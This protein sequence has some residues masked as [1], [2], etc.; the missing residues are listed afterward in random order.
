MASESLQRKYR[1][2]YAKLL[3][4]Y[5]KPYRE[6]FGETMGQT[7]ND[8]CRER[9]KA[10]KGLLSFVL[11]TFFETSAAIVRENATMIVRCCM[12]RGSTIFLRVVISLIAMAAL[13][14]CIFPLPRMVGQEAAKTPDTAW[15]VYLFL[16]GAY[17][18]AILFFVALYQAFKLLTYVD[19]NKAF[20]ELSAGALGSI[21]YCA[22]TI[23]ILMVGGIAA[24]MALSFG[25]GED[26]AGLVA[27]GLLVT[28]A[29]SV[30]AAIAAVL[31]KQVRKAIDIK[32]EGLS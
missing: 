24:L 31:Q 17:I 1:N 22:M 7:F 25:K 2:W 6:R 10:E 32:S 8:L 12:N 15:L 27:M 9:A 13:A 5:P 4:L 20:S 11:W 16:V 21:K 18:M 23:N 29:S 26:I 14:V 3:R 30:V 19:G 28:F